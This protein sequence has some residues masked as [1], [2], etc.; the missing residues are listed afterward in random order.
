MP[1]MADVHVLHCRCSCLTLQM[2]MPHIADAI[3]PERWMLKGN[4]LK[5]NSVNVSGPLP[6]LIILGK[7]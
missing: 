6:L 3:C 7:Y 1:Y 4:G 5:F 2:F